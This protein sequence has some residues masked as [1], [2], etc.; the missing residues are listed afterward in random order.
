MEHTMK[1]RAVKTHNDKTWF[2][3][4]KIRIT[5]D[6]F[7][8]LDGKHH[9]HYPRM[10]KAHFRCCGKQYEF[11]NTDGLTNVE[12]WHREELVPKYQMLNLLKS[13]MP[14]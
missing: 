3:D 14:A 12:D 1:L 2:T 8:Y 9:M 6:G 5:T 13:P 11:N 4:G 10:A 7:S